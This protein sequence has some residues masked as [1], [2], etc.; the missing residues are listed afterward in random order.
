MAKAAG[1]HATQT[2]YTTAEL[3]TWVPKIYGAGPVFVDVKVTTERDALVLPP[4]DGT[5]LRLLTTDIDSQPGDEIIVI[6]QSAG[7]GGY[8]SATAFRWRHGVLAH[9]ASVSDLPPA[10]D[11]VDA[12]KRALQKR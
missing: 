8:L 11:A 5:L 9:V 12:L 3:K 10:A 1:F 6:S 2:I 7:S 4:R